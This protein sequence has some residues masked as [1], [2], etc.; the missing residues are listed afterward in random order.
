MRYSPARF[1]GFIVDGLSRES[2][3]LRSLKIRR[4]SFERD[5]H[6]HTDTLVEAVSPPL[7]E[8]GEEWKGREG[9]GGI[10]SRDIK[11]TKPRGISSLIHYGNTFRLT[12][13]A[14]QP[15]FVFF[16]SRSSRL[17]VIWPRRFDLEK[18]KRG[19]DETCLIDVSL[20]RLKTTIGKLANTLF[21]FF[22]RLE[23]S[24]CW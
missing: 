6:T 11:K 10:Y 14:S 4:N 16:A 15:I 9:G 22:C 19:D 13:A 12:G 21:F 3:C 24:G 20:G 17:S 7:G 8:G 5:T 1:Y 2:A 23:N 18:Q